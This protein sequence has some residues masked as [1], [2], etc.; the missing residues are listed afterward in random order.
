[1]TGL[2]TFLDTVKLDKKEI[3]QLL[4]PSVEYPD[5]ALGRV[6]RGEQELNATQLLRLSQFVGCSADDLLNCSNWKRIAGKSDE[7]VVV[8]SG[9]WTARL[10][11]DEGV[12]RVYKNGV[13]YKEEVL[14][15][16]AITLSDYF[17]VLNNVILNPK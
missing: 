2:T 15:A 14:H 6:L 7:T 10:F 8:R 17:A 11:M 13:L 16:K 4:F 3:A 12:T 9:K 1:M 5:H